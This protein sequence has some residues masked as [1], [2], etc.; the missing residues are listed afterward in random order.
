M[1]EDL[2]HD[3]DELDAIEP[4]PPPVQP[5]EEGEPEPTE[6]PHSATVIAA[7][8]AFLGLRRAVGG[9][10][11]DEWVKVPCRVCGEET[12]VLKAIYDEV[13]LWNKREHQRGVDAEVG[14]LFWKPDYINRN[15]IVACEGECTLKVRADIAHA[16]E[17]ERNTTDHYLA[18]IKQGQGYLSPDGASWLRRHG[19]ADRVTAYY[20]A[21]ATTGSAT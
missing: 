2:E 17:V 8:A 19:Y 21:P 5:P 11:E 7:A 10:A 1:Y 16:S 13:K 14:G 9:G 3:D 4:P 6:A 18:Q 12:T 20:N 15:Q